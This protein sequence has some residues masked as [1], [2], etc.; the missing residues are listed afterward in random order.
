LDNQAGQS[1]RLGLYPALQPYRTGRLPVSDLHEVYFEESGNP[2]GMPVL[3]VHGG[4]GGGSNPVMRRFH[5]PQVYRI[6]LFDQRGCG[7][8]V[9]HAELREN[10]TWHL[11]A[12][13]EQL[14]THLGIERWNLMG[15]SW[16]STLSLAYAVMHPART[17]SLLLRGIFLMRRKEVEWFYQAGCNQLFPDAYEP[18]LQ[19]IP[20]AER[21]DMV[22]AYYRRLTGADAAIR[23]AAA[24]T[25]SVWEGSTLTLAQNP[26]REQAFA[27]NKFALAFARIEAHYFQHRGFFER[28]GFL[29]AEARRIRHI[30]ATVVHGRYDVVTP[31]AN[32]WDLK[33]VLPELD[34]RIVPDAGHAMSEPGIIHELIAATRRGATHAYAAPG[35]LS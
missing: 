33:A 12:D 31:L 20:E 34:L 29:L 32:A 3:L 24:K 18:F 19:L 17:V 23:N 2:D 21:H 11:I 15:G 13:M 22:A 1:T 7:R 9:P 10:T 35:S 27:D 25:W 14:R 26:N 8:S 28:D 4:P 30:P 16:G 6:I 5:D